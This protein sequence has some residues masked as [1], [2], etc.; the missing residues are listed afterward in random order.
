M[1][2]LGQMAT[3]VSWAF[4]GAL[5]RHQDMVSQGHDAREQA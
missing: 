3:R 4:V 1:K 2:N 5:A